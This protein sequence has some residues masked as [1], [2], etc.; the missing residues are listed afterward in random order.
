MSYQ[1]LKPDWSQIY[2]RESLGP[3]SLPMAFFSVLYGAGV[4]LRLGAYHQGL[5][6]RKSLPGFV[7]SI[8]NITAGGTGKTPASAM[9]A[10][11][12]RTQGYRVAI[13]SRGYGGGYRSE[14]LEVS[15]GHSIKAD[16]HETGDEAYLLARRLSGVPVVLSKRRYLAGMYAHE[17][18]G[19]E[20]F[21]LDDGFQHLEIRPDLNIALI[22][23]L[24]P[25]GNGHLLPWGLLREP[26]NQ[27]ARADAFILTRVGEQGSGEKAMDLLRE[28]FP[29][30]RIFRA[31]H[32]P[33]GVVFPHTHL[34]L[35]ADSL[36]GRRILAF[37]GIAQPKVLRDALLRL[38]ADVV[39]FKG[40]RDHY[41]FREDEIAAI[42]QRS[43][44][45]GAD[46]LLTTEKDWVRIAGL[47]PVCTQMGYLSVE[48]TL[49]SGQADFFGMIRN[50]IKGK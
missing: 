23:A 16:P 15:D 1:L 6:K 50:A 9:L 8:G 36:S 10:G 41:Q 29:S 27:L 19:T 30:I 24:D 5:F 28:K 43:E 14:V 38:G 26:V 45:L 48:F 13:L 22:D 3:W 7:V 21:I 18:F 46:F 20:L 33:D 49:V 4:R 34:T 42:I 40:F 25:F 44:A 32:R 2:K 47:A 11:W 17:K 35:G 31:D 37:A 39:Y 12:A